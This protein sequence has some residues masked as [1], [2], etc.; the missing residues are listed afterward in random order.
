FTDMKSLPD[1]APVAG[2]E[3]IFEMPWDDEAKALL[4]M[5]PPAF[6]AEAV[7]ETEKYACENGCDSVTG[8]VAD[9]YRKKLGF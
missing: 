6:L 7:S 3:P 4:E 9:A 5:V 2:P 1:A 8:A